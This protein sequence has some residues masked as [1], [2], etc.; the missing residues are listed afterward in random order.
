MTR[1]QQNVVFEHGYVLSKLGSD[2]V[3][4]LIKESVEIPNNI[5]GIVYIPLDSNKGWKLFLAKE[6]KHSGYKIDLNSV[7]LGQRSDLM[8][9]AG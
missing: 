4:A 8:K 1:A 5:S 3:C 6:M 9:Y 2:N 7:V